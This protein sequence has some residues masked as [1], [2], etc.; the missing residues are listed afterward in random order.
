MIRGTKKS[1]EYI[2]IYWMHE[3]L[4]SNAAM[5]YIC[6]ETTCTYMCM[7]TL[8]MGTIMTCEYQPWTHTDAHIVGSRYHHIAWFEVLFCWATRW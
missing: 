4:H 7:T 6:T 3:S 5:E 8:V 2:W 1:L